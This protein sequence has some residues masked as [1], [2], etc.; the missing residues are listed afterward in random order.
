MFTAS[1]LC[2]SFTTY[3][4]YHSVLY[5]REWP[6]SIPDFMSKIH[7]KNIFAVFYFPEKIFL[8]NIAKIKHWQIKYG[9][10]QTCGA[11]GPGFEPGSCPL[12]FRDWVSPAYTRLMLSEIG[13]LVLAI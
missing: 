5:I 1:K 3:Y 9:L 6:I 10:Q 13:S 11:R 12:G 7:V 8:T 2:D 4:L